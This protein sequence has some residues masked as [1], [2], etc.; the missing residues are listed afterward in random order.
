MNLVTKKSTFKNLLK[1]LVDWSAGDFNLYFLPAIHTL[2]SFVKIN[3][4]AHP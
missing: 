3:N 1:S 4:P 2:A